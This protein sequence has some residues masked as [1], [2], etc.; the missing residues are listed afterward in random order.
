VVYVT[1]DHRVEAVDHMKPW[2][3]G[4]NHRGVRY[5]IELP[6][7]VAAR[8]DTQPGDQLRVAF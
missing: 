1:G 4:R 7:G 8:T 6:A 2:A 3:I 5:V